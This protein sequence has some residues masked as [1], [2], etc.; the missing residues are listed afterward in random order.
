[1]ITWTVSIYQHPWKP[2]SEK[3]NI[4]NGLICYCFEYS[5]NDIKKDYMENGKSTIMEKI[6]LEKRFGN[7]QCATKAPKGK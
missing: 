1:L 3:D 7:C 5:V 2:L 4:V 6:Q